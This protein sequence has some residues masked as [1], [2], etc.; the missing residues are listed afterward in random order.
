MGESRAK[1]IWF[2]SYK[3][4]SKI[5]LLKKKLEDDPLHHGKLEDGAEEGP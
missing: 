3:I 4:C 2:I 5:V 1:L